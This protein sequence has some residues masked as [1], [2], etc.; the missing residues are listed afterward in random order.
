MRSA[1][2]AGTVLS[3]ATAVLFSL[4]SPASAVSCVGIRCD[5]QNPNTTGCASDPQ[6]R[7]LETKTLRNSSGTAV[8]KVQLRW[9]PV[10][11]S[12]WGRVESF[13][14]KRKLY[15]R[16]NQWQSTNVAQST[17]PYGTVTYT[18]MKPMISGRAYRAYGEVWNSSNTGKW[19]G[20]TQW[21]GINW[22]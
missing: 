9:S 5:G 19:S 16:V 11:Q 3:L 14:G 6:T 2:R 22:I 20:T 15:V 4:G 8:G 12:T 10:C 18:T 17:N 7:S 21:Y 1:K 13:V